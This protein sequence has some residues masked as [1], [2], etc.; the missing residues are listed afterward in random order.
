MQSQEERANIMRQLD[1]ER[2]ELR[3]IK[4]ALLSRI[5]RLE[6]DE[7][8]LRGD[9]EHFREHVAFFETRMNELTALGGRPVRNTHS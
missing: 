2:D 5:K 4:V 3:A 8:A 9:E 6:E 1:G 7:G